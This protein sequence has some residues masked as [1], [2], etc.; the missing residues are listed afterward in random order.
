MENFFYEF[1]LYAM[2]VLGI[3]LV[4]FVHELG[5]FLAAR[6]CGVRVDVFSLGFGPKLLGWKRGATTYQLS[7]V[8]LGGYVRMAGEETSAG[9]A[10]AA[11]ELQSKSVGA[12]FLIFSG[13]VI[14]NVIFAMV[15][16]PIILMT[17]VP[18]PSPTIGH[19]VP[20][21]PA[22]K[23]GL[24]PGTRV[25]QVNGND[26]S[27]FYHIA[28]E[29]ALGSPEHTDLVVSSGDEGSARTV[30]VTPEYD[31]EMGIYT[32]GVMPGADPSGAVRVVPKGA[33]AEAGLETGD[34]ITAVV[35]APLGLGIENQLAAMSQGDP[36]QLVVERADGT[37]FEAQV[38]PTPLQDGPPRIGLE[39]RFGRVR[40]LRPTALVLATGLKRDD[41]ILAVDGASVLRRYDLLRGLQAASAKGSASLRVLRDGQV[42]DLPSFELPGD[43]ALRLDSDL[44]L[45]HA[46]DARVAVAQGSAAAEAGLFS[47][48]RITKIGER[49]IKEYTDIL[50]VSRELKQGDTLAVT[51]EREAPDGTLAT[52]TLD[53]T[54]RPIGPGSYG[55]GLKDF[56]YV[57]RAPSPGVAVKVGI[58]SSWKFAVESWL[59]LK[60]ILLGHVSSKNI[61][62]IITI[63]VVSHSWAA[64]GLAKLLFFLCMLSMNLAFLNILPIPV[65]DG[66]HLFFLAIE[67]LKGSPVS[68]KVMAH[69]QLVGVVLIVSLMV[70]VT[71]NDVMRWI[72][73]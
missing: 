12:R 9:Q 58:A 68:D 32:I 62:G 30:R 53:V 8:P 7:L 14:M 15:V 67:K 24:E 57:Y 63:G 1:G 64:D 59:T 56:S 52:L 61:G 49:E 25:H 45:G 29:V 41:L 37:T 44:A 4:I 69:S 40:D 48:D 6:W 42:V 46:E 39:P 51:V 16:F 21:G 34:R 17:G 10:P 66:G 28:Q 19:V 36:L 47:G 33:A 38:V 71:F 31:E 11:D 20:G 43:A 2:V 60:R 22:W 26:I 54:P 18:L 70:Y 5:H 72:V 50:D 55:F 3:S 27:S 73:N 35:G 13:G 23:A 65:L